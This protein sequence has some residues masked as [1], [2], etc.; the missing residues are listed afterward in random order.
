MFMNKVQVIAWLALVFFGSAGCTSE[1]TPEKSANGE[2][3]IPKDQ[4]RDGGPGKDGIP[5]VDNPQFKPA[6]N[7]AQLEPDDLVIG[8]VKKGKAK[9]YGHPIMDHHEIVN[10]KVAGTPIAITYCPL[11]GT[12]IAY[13]REIKGEVTT[14]GV[15]G[16][17]YNN[18]LI[19]YDRKTNSNWSQMLMKAVNGDLKGRTV[20]T[21]QV[22][23]TEWAT[24]QQMYP[25][26]RVLSRK[27]GFSRNY[28]RYPYGDFKTSEQLLFPV[29]NRD[30]RLHEKTRVHGIIVAEQAFAY[31]LETFGSR[32]EVKQAKLAGK[33]VVVVGN[34]AANF[35]VSFDLEASFVDNPDLEALQG[36]LPRIMKD[37]QGNE[38]DIFGRV[39]QGPDKGKRLKPTQSYMGYWFAWAAFFP[40]ITLRGT[41]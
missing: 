35:T 39:V 14:F 20:E 11:T 7:A 5:S 31:P 25:E 6:T 27:T 1:D 30:S 28:E 15:S 37:E 18:N 17:L 33:P 41:G 9:A 36:K 34:Q 2:W 21:Y 38:Y 32:T 40:D 3:L 24:W 4:V 23:E 12:G 10:D 8:I 19:P 16:L 13:D 29:S 26:T 22:V